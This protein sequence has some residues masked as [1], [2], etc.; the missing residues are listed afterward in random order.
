MNYTDFIVS[1]AYWTFFFLYSFSYSAATV[2]LDL[3]ELT[4]RLIL[5]IVLLTNV[6][7]IPH[8]LT[9]SAAT[10]A[11]VSQV[12]QVI[13]FPSFYFWVLLILGFFLI[14]WWDIFV[15]TS[16]KEFFNVIYQ[17]FLLRLQI[18]WFWKR[19]FIE[20]IFHFELHLLYR[21]TTRLCY[22]RY[23]VLNLRSIK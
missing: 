9:R 1:L 22:W 23:L 4:V 3:K 5:M 7:I 17:S 8:V 12:S 21:R 13:E 15:Y 6:Q 16:L 11:S 19:Y 20:I 14:S 18:S 10:T 2:H